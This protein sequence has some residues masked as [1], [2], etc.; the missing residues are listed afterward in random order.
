MGEQLLDDFID[1]TYEIRSEYSNSSLPANTSN[2][3][4]VYHTITSNVLLA[5][6]ANKTG[7]TVEYINNT[8]KGAYASAKHIEEAYQYYKDLSENDRPLETAQTY[9]EY[10]TSITLAQFY[11]CF[12]GRY[13]MYVA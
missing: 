2:W 1:I 12:L 6:L 13:F 8:I 3:V 7:L 5:E 11:V 9:V 10:S 4:L